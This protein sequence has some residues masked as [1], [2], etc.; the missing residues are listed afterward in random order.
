MTTSVVWKITGSVKSIQ[1]TSFFLMIIYVSENRQSSV[2]EYLDIVAIAIVFYI[3][4]SL[5]IQYIFKRVQLNGIVIET[6]D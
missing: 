6:K 2:L 5:Y 4:M 1:I 3:Y